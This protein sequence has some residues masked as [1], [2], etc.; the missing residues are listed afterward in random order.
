MLACRSLLLLDDEY[1]VLWTSPSLSS[2]AK[3]RRAVDDSEHD[4]C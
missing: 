1:G 4:E 2:D 3:R